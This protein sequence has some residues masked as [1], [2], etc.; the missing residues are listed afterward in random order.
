MANMQITTMYFGQSMKPDFAPWR[1]CY[2]QIV[3]EVVSSAPT[4]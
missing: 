3:N 2:F 4:A 1:K